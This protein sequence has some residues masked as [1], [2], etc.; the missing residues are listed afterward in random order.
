MMAESPDLYQPATL[1]RLRGCAAIP[2]AEFAEAQSELERVRAEGEQL[3][4]SV[5]VIVTPTCLVAAPKI[6]DLGAMTAPDLRAYEVKYLLGNT[7][8]FSLLFWPSVSVPCGFTGDGLPVGLQISA[9]PGADD[10][11]LR[12]AYAYEQATE[13]HKQ[14]P[15][16]AL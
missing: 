10:L 15:Q 4:D 16:L 14:L 2:V 12:L 8:P 3:F 11:A 13:W 9:R 1:E 5:D 6:S 7:A